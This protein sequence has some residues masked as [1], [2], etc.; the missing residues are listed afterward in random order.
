VRANPLI[1]RGLPANIFLFTRPSIGEQNNR[2]IELPA[3]CVVAHRVAN[4][5]F[6]YL[7]CGVCGL[8]GPRGTDLHIGPL[9]LVVLGCRGTA[10]LAKAAGIVASG[11]TE[12]LSYMAFPREHWSAISPTAMRH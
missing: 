5:L 12:T 6:R 8:R 3:S 2:K 10:K 9:V 4:R 11:V 7:S 1:V